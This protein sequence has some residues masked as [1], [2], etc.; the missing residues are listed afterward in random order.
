MKTKV[1]PIAL[2]CWL[3]ICLVVM[4]NHIK[5][6]T[7]NYYRTNAVI[8]SIENSIVLQCN[9][10]EI[11]RLPYIPTYNKGQHVNVIFNGNQIVGLSPINE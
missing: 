1:I 3:A 6:E 8:E 9:N 7:R 2:F 4:A 11:W 5:M 10:G